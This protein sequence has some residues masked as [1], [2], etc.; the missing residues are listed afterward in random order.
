MS[1]AINV[2]SKI[3]GERYV[4]YDVYKDNTKRAEKFVLTLSALF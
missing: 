1:T 3:N 4:D 2:I